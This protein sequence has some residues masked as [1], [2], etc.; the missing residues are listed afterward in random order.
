MDAIAV[1]I[2]APARFTGIAPC[3]TNLTARQVAALASAIDLPDRGLRVALDGDTAG[4]TAA[5]R[6]YPL[7]LP[8]GANITAVMLPDG[9]D[10]ADILASDGRDA[11]RETLTSS[12]CPMADLV[13]DAKIEQWSRGRETLD[14]EGQIGALRAAADTL[15]AMPPAE[16]ARQARRVAALFIRRYDWPADLVNCE[17]IDA[18]ERYHEHPDNGEPPTAT[19]SRTVSPAILASRRPSTP[20]RP[21]RARGRSDQSGR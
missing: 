19:P 12:V 17:L 18:V 1:S 20:A 16:A 13:I 6:A 4:R 7:L 15:A 2:A 3:G 21:Q 5:T 8:S 9:K 14:T 10:P 11:L